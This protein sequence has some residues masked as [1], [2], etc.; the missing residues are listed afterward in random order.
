MIEIDLTIGSKIFRVPTTVI[1]D[2][3]AYMGPDVKVNA[4]SEEHAKTVA[5]QAG[6][7]PNPHFPPKEIKSWLP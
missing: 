4:R 2:G 1:R 5:Q 6:H 3:I 7:I